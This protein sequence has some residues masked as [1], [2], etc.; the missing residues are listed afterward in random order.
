MPFA[1]LAGGRTRD[2]AALQRCRPEPVDV[3]NVVS[4]HR[5][6]PAMK[7]MGQLLGVGLALAISMPGA[8]ARP[9]LGPAALLL[10]PLAIV[11]GIA[12]ATLGSRKARA[13][14]SY[15]LKSKARRGRAVREAR[16]AA[17]RAHQARRPAPAVAAVPAVPLPEPR[18]DAAPERPRAAAAAAATTGAGWAGPLFWPHAY[19]GVFEYALGLPGDDNQ[20]W[21]R[22]F[23][24]VIDGM[25]A[26]P[27]RETTGRGS[28]E[29]LRGWQNLCGSEAPAAPDAT[30]ARIREVIAPTAEQQQAL[31]ELRDALARATERIARACPA[32]RPAD[33]PER[34]ALMIARLTAM[35][36]AVTTVQGPL[37]AFYASLS[38]TQKVALEGIG[39]GDA[40]ADPRGADS[41]AAGCAAP[42]ANW[43][44]ARIER[45]LRPTAEQKMLL[46]KLRQTA[47][48]LA[49]Y[50]AST[51]PRETPRTAPERL[52]AI[53]ER[54]A[55]LR[56]AANV[57]WPAHRL[58]YESLTDAQKARFQT[59]ARER[60]ANSAR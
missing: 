26:Q 16:P 53:Q 1:L 49:Q 4:A 45:V 43:P 29:G 37:R 31:D 11:G 3:Q 13:H 5:G 40:A 2:N 21:A 36:Q 56:Y 42:V 20:F 17:T 50:V 39:D 19:D 54:L 8:Q 51:C 41:T 35:R 47:L 28:A 60:R 14:R 34:L 44:Q 27:A 23:G 59:I 7:V 52:D 32:G 55:A 6:S 38:D 46:D 25:F 10:A 18:P 58:F 22:G 9:K 33:P 57:V 30:V 48:G 15:Q 12:G 24:D